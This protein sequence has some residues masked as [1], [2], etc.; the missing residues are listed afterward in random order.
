MGGGG[1]AAAARDPKTQGQR[2]RIA[3]PGF[4]LPALMLFY[5][6]LALANPAGNQVR[7]AG[8]MSYSFH[9]EKVRVG[10]WERMQLKTNRAQAP[11]SVK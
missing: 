5:Q 10:I 7:G 8:F 9:K 2:R 4:L 11:T 3:S 6:G 1:N